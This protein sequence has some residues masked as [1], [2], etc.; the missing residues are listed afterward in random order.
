MARVGK[1]A[2]ALLAVG[3]LA[4]SACGSG[5]KD[6]EPTNQGEGAQTNAKVKADY[7]QTSY[8]KIKQG[9]ELHLAIGEITPQQNSWQQDMTAET[10]TLWAWYNPNTMIYDAE[11]NPTPDPDYFSNV[12]DELKDGKRV[13]TITLNQAAKWNDG[14]DMDWHSVEAGWKACGNPEGKYLCNSYDGYD[15][16]ESIKQ[17][18]N[19]KTAVVTFENAYP[20]WQGLFGGLLNPNYAKDPDTFNT[21]AADG[22]IHPEWGAGPYKVSKIDGV[23]N[24]AEFVPNEKWWGKDKAK[25][26]KVTYTGME[27]DASLNAFANGQ[28]DAT[29]VSSKER[30]SRVQNVQGIELRRGSTTSNGLLTLNS[31]SPVLADQEVREAVFQGIDRSITAKISFEGLGYT[32]PLPGSFL[33]FPFQKGYRDNFGLKYDKEAAKKTLDAAGWAAGSDG[34]RAKD[35]KKLELTFPVFGDAAVALNRAKAMASMLKEIGVNLKI[36]QR[37]SKDFSKVIKSKSFDMLYSGFLSSDP[38]GVAYTGQIWGSTSS[39]NKSGTG[40]KEIDAKIAEMTKLP[41]ADEQIARANDIEKEAFET[42]GLM[43]LTNG[44]TIIAAKKGLA[45]YGAYVYAVPR[46]QDIGWLA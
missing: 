8:D 43:P 42:R 2:I 37:P 30:L 6:S 13:V 27:T 5:S 45:N 31:K 22:K 28:I 44:V 46:K 32:E 16:I 19:A 10:G 26:T 3:S 12:K 14:S 38:Y 34:I 24:Y 23:K 25:L 35:G 1:S 18:D 20:W 40:T 33:L 9:G 41:T 4:L 11:G 39:L 36:D 17:G 29:G 7:K 15:Q 21:G